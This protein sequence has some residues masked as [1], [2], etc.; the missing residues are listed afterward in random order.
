MKAGDADQQKR[1]QE[2][3]CRHTQ[4]H[5]GP[6][7]PAVVGDVMPGQQAHRGEN[8]EQKIGSE[9][10]HVEKLPQPDVRTI[11][12]GPVAQQQYASLVRQDQRQRKNQARERGS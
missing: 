6:Y 3:F 2:A 10:E 4:Q 5:A 9:T 8:R 12:W 7:L 1:P 11:S